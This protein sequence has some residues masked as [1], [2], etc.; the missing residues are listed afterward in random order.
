MLC[1]LCFAFVQ[2][3]LCAQF[4]FCTLFLFPPPLHPPPPPHQ[5]QVPRFVSVVLTAAYCLKVNCGLVSM[6]TSSF[7]RNCSPPLSLFERHLA[8]DTIDEAFNSTILIINEYQFLPSSL[9]H[10]TLK[11]PDHGKTCTYKQT[12]PMSIMPQNLQGSRCLKCRESH[13]TDKSL[14]S[15]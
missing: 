6:V 2:L 14:S 9:Q 12:D 11:K 4:A 10:R 8:S 7:L 3:L 15:G 13:S 5:S 1:A